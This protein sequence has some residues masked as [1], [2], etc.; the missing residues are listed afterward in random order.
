MNAANRPS[1]GSRAPDERAR[2]ESEAYDGGRVHEVSHRWHAR[3]SHVLI[4][5]NTMRAEAIFASLAA[6]R[7]HN[8][9][10]MDV[11]CGSGGL[12]AQL[13]EHGARSVYGF[14]VSRR[15]IELA[16]SAYGDLAGVTFGVRAADEPIEGT[17]DLVIGRSILHHIDF[18]RVLPT[19]FERNLAPGGLMLFME[20]TSHPL[21]MLFH[22]LV[23]SAHTPDEWPLTP[24]DVGWLRRSLD[25]RV[26]PVNLLSFPAGAISSVT[27]RSA[28]NALMRAADRIDQA[29]ERRAH[30]AA[31]GRQGIIVIERPASGE[32]KQPTCY[33]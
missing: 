13:H 12:S 17:F 23:R 11:G 6:T 1:A 2:R 22:A 24:A 28:D 20:P 33:S 26:R 4:G 30:L 3:M 27:C 5:P 32:L 29:L 8:G 9:D 16:R 7:A 19:L 25:A 18:R 15:E 21:G 10:V 14:D 31:R